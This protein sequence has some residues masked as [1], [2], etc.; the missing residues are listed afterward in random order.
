MNVTSNKEC[1]SMDHANSFTAKWDLR[2][3]EKKGQKKDSG[4][5]SKKMSVL[6]R[7]SLREN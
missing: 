7:C 1:L 6:L 2:Q 4:T 5:N 3:Q